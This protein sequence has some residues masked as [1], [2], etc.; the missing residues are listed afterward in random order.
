LD[1]AFSPFWNGFR[2]V[3]CADGGLKKEDFPDNEMWMAS[4]CLLIEEE[5][6]EGMAIDLTN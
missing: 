2:V 3:D 5:A 4:P 6:F 1:D